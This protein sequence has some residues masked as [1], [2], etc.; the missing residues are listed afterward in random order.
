MKKPQGCGSANE[1]V[2]SPTAKNALV[3]IPVSYVA[4]QVTA[5][6][7]PFEYPGNKIDPLLIDE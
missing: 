1:I 6:C 7:Y 5:N 3:Q 4:A 2:V